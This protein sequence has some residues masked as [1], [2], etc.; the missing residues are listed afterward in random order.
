MTRKIQ[1]GDKVTYTGLIHTEASGV[2]VTGQ[3]EANIG[4]EWEVRGVGNAEVRLTHP[5]GH[6]Y[7]F[8]LA[9]LILVEGSSITSLYTKH[10]DGYVIGDSEMRWA[11]KRRDGERQL[12]IKY[13]EGSNTSACIKEK[14]I[15]AL[16]AALLEFM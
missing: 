8:N 11:K 9:D 4:E 10:P 6:D 16:A 2:G 13:G 12:I 15:P 1:V 7:L 5:A 14:D 3:M